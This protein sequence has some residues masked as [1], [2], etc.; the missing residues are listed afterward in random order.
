MATLQDFYPWVMLDCP[1]V[2]N[3]VMDDA[4]VKGAREFCKLTHALDSDVVITTVIA[5]SDY[6]LTLP[7]DTEIITVKKVQESPTVRLTPASLEYVESQS[8]ASGKPTFYAVVE[9]NPLSLRLYAT[10]DNVYTYTAK[11]ALMPIP[12]AAELD[13]KLLDWYSEGVTA[14][15]KYWLM[16]QPNKPWSNPDTAAFAYRQFDARVADAKV[17]R[18]Q[19]RSDLPTTVQMNPFA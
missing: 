11:F 8:A 1:N 2:P 9:T 14:Y 16:V 4:I 5:Q 15:A 10:P 13:D 3:P 7:T 12:T 18:A 17:R 6:T 19:W